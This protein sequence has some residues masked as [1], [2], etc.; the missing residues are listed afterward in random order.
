MGSGRGGGERGWAVVGSERGGGA[1][2][3]NGEKGKAL[4]AETL[5][6]GVLRLRADERC[7]TAVYLPSP[8]SPPPPSHS[9]LLCYLPV[10]TVT[11]KAADD[12][13]GW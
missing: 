9:H 6:N 12:V 1:G 4:P 10:W 8:P 13:R 11:T 3:G 5:V 7:F 2:A